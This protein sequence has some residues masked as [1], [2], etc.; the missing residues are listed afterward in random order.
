MIS[1]IEKSKK[2]VRE[3]GLP[4]SLLY[5]LSKLLAG[6]SKRIRLHYYLFVNQKISAS[7]RLPAHRG[8]NFQFQIIN[9]RVPL[10][11]ALPRPSE[12]IDNRFA[13]GYVCI[14]ATRDEEF[15]GCIWFSLHSYIED[16]VRAIFIPLPAGRAAWDFDV[17]IAPEYR[18]TYLFPKLWDEA[19]AFL[20][21]Q[22]YESTTSRIEGFNIQSV[23]SHKKLGADT[24]A[25]AVYLKAGTLQLSFCTV[26]PYLHFSFGE[27]SIPKYE[28]E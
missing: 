20:K 22:G 28:L 19:D 23:N 1:L 27:K 9:K 10:L 5:I 15:I 14:A 4:V 18:A 16:E 26:Y 12:V 25:R 6:I 13:Q 8:K 11:D 24:I 7:P 21:S 3:M 2:L 17:Y